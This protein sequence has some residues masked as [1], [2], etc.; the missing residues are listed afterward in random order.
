MFIDI[1]Y[2]IKIVK[3]AEINNKNSSILVNLVFN[4]WFLLIKKYNNTKCLIFPF[5]ITQ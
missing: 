3:Y 1:I 2:L 5:F 4:N